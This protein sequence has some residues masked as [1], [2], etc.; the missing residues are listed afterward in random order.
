MKGMIR[1]S[2]GRVY[3]AG[4]SSSLSLMLGRLESIQGSGEEQEEP[5]R[6]GEEEKGRGEK[7]L[8]SHCHFW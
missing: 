6:E 4:P 1:C 3:W 2:L 5:E 8:H 7:W